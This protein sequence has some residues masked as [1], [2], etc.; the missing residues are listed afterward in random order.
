NQPPVR[1]PRCHLPGKSPDIGDLTN[2][3][4]IPGDDLAGGI[5]CGRDE[6]ADELHCDLCSGAFELR[7]DNLGLVDADK[8]LVDLLASALTIRD[9]CNEA[10]EDLAAE[11]VLQQ[12][13]ITLGKGHDDHLV[14]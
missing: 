7:F 9:G 14:G 2:A 1:I 10:V 8:A 13:A 3:L 11:Q 4:R 6:L 12:F 5:T